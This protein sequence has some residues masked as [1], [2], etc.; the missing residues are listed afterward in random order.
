MSA[1]ILR[2][3]PESD[4]TAAVA[5]DNLSLIGVDYDIIHG[6]AVVVAALDGTSPC[7]PNLNG[8]ILRT[9][10]HPLS[11][12]ME[13]NPCNIASVAFEGK[14]RGRVRGANVEELHI[15]VSSRS[16]V[17]L[18]GGDAQAINLGVWV[19]DSP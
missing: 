17:A 16:K 7:I 8:P 11:F 1:D 13:R 12:T 14:Q 18:V 10:H 6:R 5:A 2:Q 15:E 3:V 9:C 19:L 4:A